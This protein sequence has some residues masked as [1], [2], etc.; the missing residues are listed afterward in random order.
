VR[1]AAARR[2]KRAKQRKAAPRARIARETEARAGV[3]PPRP[4]SVFG[5]NL[6]LSRVSGRDADSESPPPQLIA[7]ALLTLVL[8]SA[9][10]LA[11]TARL[12]REWRV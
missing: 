11:L 8:A 7:L 2:S 4:R 1:R 5:D 12:S 6:A 3:E 9:S 10:F